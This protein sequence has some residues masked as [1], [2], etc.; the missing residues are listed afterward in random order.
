[1]PFDLP[2]GPKAEALWRGVNDDSSEED[3][4]LWRVLSLLHD[5]WG[6]HVVTDANIDR[7]LR[8]LE[9]ELP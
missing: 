3:K 8:N 9:K 5:L 1:M 7:F 2:L 6:V 4:R